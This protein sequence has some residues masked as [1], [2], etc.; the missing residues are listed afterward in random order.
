MKLTAA[1]RA[2]SFT[3]VKPQSLNGRDLYR[4][5]LMEIGEHREG[6]GKNIARAACAYKRNH[7]GWNYR[8]RKLKN[9]NYRITR[10]S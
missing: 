8:Q 6:D 1:E 2:I 4:F 10:I 5:P 7:D 9:G 3:T